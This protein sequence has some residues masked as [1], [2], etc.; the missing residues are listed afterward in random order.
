[1][2]ASYV[3]GI[4]LAW[5]Q[6][7]FYFIILF[8]LI[9]YFLI[10]L[11]MF[12]TKF[13]IISR[14]DRFL[15]VLPLLM[16][17]GCLAMFDRMEKPE[18]FNSFEQ[19][20]TCELNGEIIRIAE[21][22][23]GFSLYIKD[24]VITIQ[25]GKQYLCSKVIVKYMF[26][27]YGYDSNE[28]SALSYH[29]GNKIHVTG[30]LK[31]F[32][33]ARNPGGF[34]EQLYYQIEDIYFF[35]EAEQITIT[36][37]D[38][39]TYHAILGAVKKKLTKVYDL[40]LSDREAGT[41]IAMLLG[42]RSLLD[43]GVKKLYQENGISHILAIS[44]LHIAL[45]GMFFFRLLKKLRCPVQVASFLTIFFIYSYGVLTDFSVSTNRAI[46][47]MVI[48]LL[49]P[50]TGKTYDMLS[51]TCL[52]ALIILLQNPMQIMS[53]GFLL[54]Y[55]AVLGIAVIYP[56]LKLLYKDNNQ[57]SEANQPAETNKLKEVKLKI[58]DKLNENKKIKNN[59]SFI[60]TILLSI[61]TQLSTIP[62]ILYFFY[63]IPVYSIIINLIILPLITI[64]TL[65]A[66]LG[67]IAG[68]IYLP[69]GVFIIGGANYILKLY[70]I[71]CRLGSGLPGNLL[72]VGKPDEL[73]LIIYFI[74]V[75]AFLI[76]IHRYRKKAT[77]LIMA[78]GLLL[79]IMPRSSGGMEIT[80]LDVG[81]GDAI[82]IES[83][84]NTTY[85]IDGGSMDVSKAGTYRI[86]PFLLSRGK[87]VLDYVMVTHSDKD[88][89]SGI[90]ELISS[91]EIKVN[92]LIL[93]DIA[94]KDEAYIMLEKQVLQKDIAVSYIK[95]GDSIKDGIMQIT[96]LHP[97]KGYVPQGSNS[98]STV[99]SIT[100]D[101][102][103]M[104]LTGDV[105]SDG[106]DMLIKQLS[107]RQDQ[108]AHNLNL[109]L[110]YTV[111]KVSHHGARSSTSEEFLSYIRP[112]VAVISCGL[113]NR[114]G[115]PH[116][117]LLKRLEDINSDTRITYETGAITIITDGKRM[118]I[119]EYLHD[120]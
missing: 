26:N 56:A 31:K 47:M 19:E 96:C 34:N 27:R 32:S 49:A 110:E 1:M 28:V 11:L 30:N 38:Y 18:L 70:E 88:H 104:L 10:Y 4:Y 41:L 20:T 78:A 100:Y 64:L 25:D 93:P 69:I 80:F 44:G 63:Q 54:S 77:I 92:N 40:M 5:Q 87:D 116:S 102:F 90:L 57:S 3:A 103:S 14:Q 35:I 29:I 12:R 17:T 83:N 68:I 55:G 86:T 72:T 46:V 113:D 37:S 7:S 79:L 119:S 58:T 67:A 60:N 101:E 66:I 71:I 52:S 62:V 42:E 51:A 48:S 81:Q 39:S 84:S 114:Y 23:F 45:I 91:G 16:L 107:K 76:L 9:I 118:Q 61:S 50:L 65:L 109:P 24:N 112:S 8:S 94:V 53:A 2:L 117:Q 13:K 15:W 89:I 120:T 85:L 98:Y 99:L 43:D 115:H 6:I 74:L 21:N 111:L 82:Y 106:E 22:E 33:A 108:G 59:N 75:S 97:A 95:A 36:D 105:Q 73:R